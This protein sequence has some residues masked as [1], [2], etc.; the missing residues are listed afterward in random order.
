MGLLVI[1]ALAKHA[2]R[3]KPQKEHIGNQDCTPKGPQMASIWTSKLALACKPV[4]IS[5]VHG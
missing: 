3:Q 5:G 1:S 2:A 4:T